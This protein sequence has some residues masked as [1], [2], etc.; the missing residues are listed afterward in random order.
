MSTTI[1]TFNRREI[2]TIVTCSNQP[3]IVAESGAG[4]L[5][6]GGIRGGSVRE[7]W[8]MVS[9]ERAEVSAAR[10]CIAR[11]CVRV[12]NTAG[13]V[14]SHCSTRRKRRKIVAVLM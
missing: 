13:I 3:A 4:C 8:R 5:G 9:S 14:I 11:C 12:V 7:I 1:V 2:S 6:I 10:V